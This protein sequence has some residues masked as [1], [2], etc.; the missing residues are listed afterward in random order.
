MPIPP[1]FFETAI[2]S[3]ALV[4]GL[5]AISAGTAAGSAPT[6]PKAPKGKAA[7]TFSKDIAPI[8][9]GHC[10]SCH[11]EGEAAPFP[12]MSYKDVAKRADLITEVTAHRIMPPWQPAPADYK[13]D[14]DISLT[15]TQL[16]LIGAWAKGGKKLGNPAE[17][18][19]PPHYTPG[20]KIG[21][22]DLVASMPKSFTI[23]A[24][25]PDI[26][27][28]FVVPL[29]LDHDVWVKTLDFHP[30]NRA[31]V[32]HS[33]FFYDSS[34][35]ARQMDGKDGQAGFAGEMPTVAASRDSILSFL[36][37]GSPT[38]KSSFGGLGGWAVGGQPVPMPADYA[39]F[40]P[41][42]SDLILSTHFH[43]DGKV[44]T[45]TSTVGLYF[46]KTPPSHAFI[47]ML[48]PVLFGVASNI[49]IPAGTKNF[50]IHD[51]FT[52]PVATTFISVSAHAHYLGK[53]FDLKAQLPDGTKKNLFTIPDWN[54]NWQTNYNY[55]PF[56]SL[57]AGTKLL[58][59]ITY[60]NTAANPRNP[61]NPPKRVT[62]GEQT[63]D[64]MG[65]VILKATT[66]NADDLKTLKQAYFMHLRQSFMKRKAGSN[67]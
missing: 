11:H 43:P 21:T 40:L 25:G 47:G 38:S 36:D 52:L 28:N 41:K 5:L 53:T 63:T 42:G 39:Y 17:A 4:G 64:E 13:L 6:K 46:S 23:P 2:T 65:S 26:Y 1:R 22:P 14:H 56:V 54:F 3:L 51:E 32:H 29:H 8:I 50:T 15:P 49:D 60:D 9:Y 20:W 16:A 57:P 7:V 10:S 19:K 67:N 59:T 33:L 18:P 12:L 45:E 35:K 30:G 55:A 37:S 27:R 44:E 34:G 48:L 62:W 61:S 66:D 24:D 58:S 31:V